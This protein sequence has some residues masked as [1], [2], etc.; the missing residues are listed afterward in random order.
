M[1]C[2]QL[3]FSGYLHFFQIPS[4]EI[5]PTFRSW[6]WVIY[7]QACLR[8][9]YEKRRRARG[10]TLSIFIMQDGVIYYA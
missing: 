10:G 4:S 3:S 1:E 6:A 8:L 9:R 7:V 2:I 5:E